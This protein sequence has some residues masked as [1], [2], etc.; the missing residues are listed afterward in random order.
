WYYYKL[1]KPKATELLMNDGRDG[2]FL[3]RDSSKGT[4]FSLAI[5]ASNR[6]GKDVKHYR[7]RLD[8]NRGY[9]LSP[10]HAFHAIPTL[11]EYHMK[12]S[13]VLLTRF[14]TFFFKTSYLNTAEFR[15]TSIEINN[16]DLIMKEQLGAGQFGK[17]HRAIYKH[18]CEVAVKFLKE[19]FDG[20]SGG[21][22]SIEIIEEAK[23]LMLLDHPNLVKIV[24]ICRSKPIKI[25]TEYLKYG[26][27]VIYLRK[28]KCALQNDCPFMLRTCRELCSGMKYLEEHHIIHRDL[29]ARNCLVGEKN[30]VKICDFGLAREVDDNNTYQSSSGALFAIR[31]TAPEG[32][33]RKIFSTKSDVWSFG[34]LMWEIFTCGVMP[35]EQYKSNGECARAVCYEDLRLQKPDNCPHDVYEIFEQCWQKVCSS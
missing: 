6:L 4:I 11:V 27:L 31:W 12:N 29:A 5:L 8:T 23:A 3:I 32:I 9:F 7:I 22:S 18:S 26:S 2:C 25:V 28:N 17:V 33:I 16:K 10:S 35:Y 21:R 20:K 24:G 13:A 19:K 34:V 1:S 14:K 15:H 30:V